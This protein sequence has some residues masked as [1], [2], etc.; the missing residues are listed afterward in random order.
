MGTN[1]SF[2]FWSYSKQFLVAADA[3]QS[4]HDSN[5]KTSRG[6]KQISMFESSLPAYYLIGHSIELSLKAFLVA[7]GCPVN[8]LRKANKY[9]HNLDALLSEARRRKLGREVT[10]NRNAEKAI[11]MLSPT[12]KGKRL[13]YMEYGKYRLPQYRFMRA[14]AKNLLDGLHRYS[15][16]SKY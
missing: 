13:E 14:V 2:G 11:R 3:V 16:N 12:Y 7:R 4:A 8:E 6:I 1:N 10:L 5:A 15:S 9:G